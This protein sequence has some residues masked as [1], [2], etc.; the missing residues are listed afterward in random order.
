MRFRALRSIAL[1]GLNLIA[2]T[3]LATSHSEG[4]PS[5]IRL[6]PTSYTLERVS[7][8]A[9]FPRGLV[10]LDGQIVVLSR[11]RVRSSG[12]VSASVQDLAGTLWTI[13]PEI[14]EPFVSAQPPSQA[15]N[16]NGRVFAKPTDPPFKI[17]D[18]AS[19]PPQADTR[20]DRP[21][22]VLRY[23]PVS[24]S[25]FLCAFS[26]IDLPQ[27]T[28]GSSFSKNS[29]DALLRYNLATG[30]WSEV[31]RHNPASSDYP[32]SAAAPQGWLQG[33]NNMWIVGRTMLAA[34][35]DNSL[36]VAYDLTDLESGREYPRSWVVLRQEVTMA[37][38]STQRHLGP[39]AFAEHGG[40]LYVAYRTTGTILRFRHGAERDGRVDTLTGGQLVARFTPFSPSP[41]Q[42]ADITDMEIDGKGR[43]IVLSAEPARLYRFTPD[44]ANVFD[45]VGPAAAAK[46]VWIDLAAHTE[47]PKMKSENVLL[48]GNGRL[49]V[50]S[51]DGHPHQNG[52]DGTIYRLTLTETDSAND[53]Q[54][55]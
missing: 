16:S 36:V 21:Y 39:S 17:W 51:S 31:E 4:A 55:R 25:L 1:M 13:N 6:S 9:P 37:D 48:D 43:L 32:S 7:T 10:E 5:S 40:W 44:P 41:R 46:R 52:A 23:D 45:A 33:P 14:A 38:G 3:S 19:D 50:T 12:G 27:K 28:T 35:K 30:K 22:C 11:G 47:N 42:S 20:T 29:S 49:F 18:R 34:A 54:P 26:G 24:K 8:V 53:A 2:S 15:I